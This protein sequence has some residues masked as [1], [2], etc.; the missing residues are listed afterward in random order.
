MTQEGSET[1][2]TKRCIMTPTRV[3]DAPFIYR[4]LN[5]PSWKRFIGDRG[6]SSIE[7]A[8]DYI[9]GKMLPQRARLGF[10]NFTITLRST[11]EPIGTCGLFDRDGVEGVDLGMAF[12]PE[13]E[14]KGYASETCEAMI[15]AAFER[16]N[17][18]KVSAITLPENTN[19]R[20]LLKRL[21]MV[22]KGSVVLPN[23]TTSLLYFEIFP[24]AN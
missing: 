14:G 16:F 12:L 1:I 24:A 2:E 10:S 15:Q 23:E 21:G 13:F 17:Q 19:A 11:G 18:P 3:E 4:L 20:N 22:K 8:A 6:I 7:D 5:T 9:A